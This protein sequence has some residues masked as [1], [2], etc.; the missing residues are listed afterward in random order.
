MAINLTKGQKIDLRKASGERLTNFCVGVNWGMIEKKG[1]FGTRKVAVDLDA[2]CAL[3]NANNEPLDIV[4]F[5]QLRSK[6]GAI[7]HSGDDLTGDADGDDGD[8]E[9]GCI[10][11]EGLDE[12]QHQID[13]HEKGD[14]PEHFDVGDADKPQRRGPEAGCLAQINQHESQAEADQA[15]DEGHRQ[16]H[17]Q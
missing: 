2:S 3:F 17:D 10:T 13:H 7:F 15:T 14:P 1:L 16:G 5:G 12:E 8:G 6:D 9:Q 11:D 4:Y